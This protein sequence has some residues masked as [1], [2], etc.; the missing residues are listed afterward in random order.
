MAKQTTVSRRPRD[1]RIN[2]IVVW[3]GVFNFNHV[4]VILYFITGHMLSSV[5]VSLTD[6]SIRE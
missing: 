1:I 5:S 6:I 2:Q 4:T 3:R